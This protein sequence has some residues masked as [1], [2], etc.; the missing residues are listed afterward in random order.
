[1]ILITISPYT[2]SPTR[3]STV[4]RIPNPVEEKLM[5]DAA[6][7]SRERRQEAAQTREQGQK[8]AQNEE[9][10]RRATANSRLRREDNE[11][12]KKAF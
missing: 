11:K 12:K 8:S 1:M 5:S 9:L 2:I 3:P 6:K 7:D 10:L 4:I